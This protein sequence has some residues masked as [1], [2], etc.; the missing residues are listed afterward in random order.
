[1]NFDSPGEIIKLLRSKKLS[2]K[3]RF[4]QNFLIEKTLRE[5]IVGILNPGKDEH[6]WEIG[7][8]IGSMTDMISAEKI[9]VFEIDRG[10]IEHLTE[11]YKNNPNILIVPGD[12]VKTWKKMWE[13]DM[14]D[15]IFGNLP[16]N[17]A[18]SIIA[19]FIKNNSIAD[20]M[21]FTVQKELGQRMTALP[22]K[23]EYS[24]F[25]VLCQ[26]AFEV[27]CHGEINP[28]AF[29]PIPKVDSVIVELKPHRRY[30]DSG[31]TPVFF[32][33]IHD[34]FLS[35]RKTIRNNILSGKL[36]RRYAREILLN[37]AEKANI[38]LSR[39][40]ETLSVSE[41]IY[42]AEVIASF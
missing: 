9:T 23:K 35:R 31:S 21:V 41:F 22:G 1:M 14:P 34:L 12:V 18:S 11:T 27:V 26:S 25:S 37:S 6:I 15:K 3:K 2:L 40:G 8:G 38:S 17:T 39:R 28:G 19:S 29:F 24:S 32:D 42:F 10:F 7:P 16:Y 30:G 36:S 33:L 5:K 4:G 13:E 20:R